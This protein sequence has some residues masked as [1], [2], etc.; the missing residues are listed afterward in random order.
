MSQSV[1]ITTE[2][3]NNQLT[4][5]KRKFRSIEQHRMESH[6]VD[7]EKRFAQ[8]V[9]WRDDCARFLSMIGQIQS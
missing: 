3:V 9:I 7:C 4:V 6:V 5:Q 8:F 2:D 1:L